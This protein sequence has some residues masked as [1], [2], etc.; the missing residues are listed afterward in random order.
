LLVVTNCHEITPPF[1]LPLSLNSLPLRLNA[2]GENACK[3]ARPNEVKRE[4]LM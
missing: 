4:R 3:R 1:S 2:P